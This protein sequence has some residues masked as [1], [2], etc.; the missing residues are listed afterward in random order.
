MRGFLSPAQEARR[1]PCSSRTLSTISSRPTTGKELYVLTIGIAS[2]FQ[3]IPCRRFS[4][5]NLAEGRNALIGPRHR[6]SVDNRNNP[7][8]EERASPFQ[9]SVGSRATA[10][11]HE[12]LT[13][14]WA[15]LTG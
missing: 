15:T 11:S 5:D 12:G 2:P 6:F 14:S 1:S 4:V 10:W 9:R 8:R 13:S 7:P 3:R